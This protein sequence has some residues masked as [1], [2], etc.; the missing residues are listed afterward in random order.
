MYHLTD[1][2][3]Q[4][5]ETT[6]LMHNKVIHEF[7]HNLFSIKALRVYFATLIKSA[8]FLLANSPLYFLQCLT[9]TLAFRA[10]HRDQNYV[11]IPWA[12]Y[13]FFANLRAIVYN[14]IEA[15][16][17]GKGPVIVSS[18]YALERY[19]LTLNIDR[20]LFWDKA[21]YHG[22]YNTWEYYFEPLSQQ[23]I[24]FGFIS[25][26]NVKLTYEN[27][28][29]NHDEDFCKH[30]RQY[31]YLNEHWARI[32]GMS[33]YP[34]P[35]YRRQ[36]H[37]TLKKYATVKYT[38]QEKVGA[39]YEQHMSGLRV[40]GLHIR[41]SDYEV[42]EGIALPTKAYIELIEQYSDYEKIYLA[43]DCEHTLQHMRRIF[44][45][46]L[47]Y[48]NV[49]RGKNNRGI[50][51]LWEKGL[52]KPLLGEEALIEALLLAR[53][54]FF[55]HGNSSMNFAVLCWNPDLDHININDS[56]ALKTGRRQE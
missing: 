40:V 37:A 47:L 49:T 11:Y 51:N 2:T 39:F 20:N 54:D 30:Y 42:K 46:R 32:S 1:K 8:W 53:C 41:R 9:R 12:G 14:L 52:C 34:T 10:R 23:S 18:K 6:F 38:I 16:E 28:R 56:T 33:D 44:D 3:Q 7:I 27:P 25:I 50:H 19:N 26:R 36:M 17:Q 35:D 31:G 13:G 43:T 4:A 22:A 48:Y 5:D 45:T 15:E 24:N 55:I 21:G 29:F